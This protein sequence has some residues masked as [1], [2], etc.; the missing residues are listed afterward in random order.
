LI[1]FDAKFLECKIVNE[2]SVGNSTILY[3]AMSADDHYIFLTTE[4]G[5]LWS[6]DVLGNLLDGRKERTHYFSDE[7]L[8]KRED[9]GQYDNAV[10]QLK[11]KIES[12]TL[13]HENAKLAKDEQQGFRLNDMSCKFLVEIDNLKGVCL[14]I[15]F[16]ILLVRW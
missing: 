4:D 14:H 16:L 13:E 9:M 1:E 6:F 12:M 2:I 8:I 3:F 10:V 7:L 15:N 11:S 5:Y